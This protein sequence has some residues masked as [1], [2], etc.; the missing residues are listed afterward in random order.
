MRKILVALSITIVIAIVSFVVVAN[1]R[2]DGSPKSEAR[3]IRE[4]RREQRQ[5]AMERQIDS[6]VLARTF[7]FTP[8]SFQRQPAGRMQMVSNPN[9]EVRIDDGYADI[10]LPYIDGIT[11]PY[12]HVILNYTVTYL[13]GY[14]TVQTENGWQITFKSSLYSA[15]DYTF[16]FEVSSK[17]G[18]TTLSVDNPFGNDVTYSGVISRIY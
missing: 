2:Q 7:R 1:S 13:E 8:Q 6:I 15:S 12:R 16:T 4:Q 18:T 14:T 10:F 11:P 9:F 17:F 3:Q 5:A